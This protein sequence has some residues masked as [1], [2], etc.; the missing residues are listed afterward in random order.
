MKRRML[1]RAATGAPPD[2]GDPSEK[3]SG[4]A[5]GAAAAAD[6][7][8]AAPVKADAAAGAPVAAPSQQIDSPRA[9][10]PAAGDDADSALEACV[11]AMLERDRTEPL[12]GSGRHV[13][14]MLPTDGVPSTRFECAAR[15]SLRQLSA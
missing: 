10:R 7:P 5:A 15:A 6:P 13:L 11:V 3:H 4:E 9:R 14:S 1:M 8:A 12:P 2:G